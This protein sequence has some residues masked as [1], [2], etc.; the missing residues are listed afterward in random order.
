MLTP[1]LILK[2]EPAHLL[3]FIGL[4]F[5]LLQRSPFHK[6]IWSKKCFIQVIVLS[7]LVVFLS[8]CVLQVI[9]L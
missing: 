7:V 8:R 5:V 4:S 9:S 1:L 3:M 2:L 6:S